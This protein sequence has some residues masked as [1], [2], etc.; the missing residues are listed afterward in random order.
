MKDGAS[1]RPLLKNCHVIH[2]ACAI[3]LFACTQ[4]SA[5]IMDMDFR[6]LNYADGLPDLGSIQDA[7][8]DPLG[9]V[10]LAYDRGLFRYDGHEVQRLAH[11]PTDSTS[12]AEEFVRALYVAADGRVWVGTANRG[13]SIFDPVTSRFSHIRSEDE[14]GPIPA[15]SIWSFYEDDFEMI[16]MAANPGLIRHDVENGTFEHFIFEPEGYSD[17]E[18]DFLNDGRKIL[19]DPRDPDRLLFATRGGLLAFDKQQ[20]SF[21]HHRM[22]YVGPHQLDYLINDF[23][24]TDSSSL[25]MGTWSGH[26][27]LYD[28]QSDTWRQFVDTHDQSGQGIILT[29]MRR[30]KHSLWVVGT[31]GFGYFNMEGGTYTY[32][33]HDPD[34]PESIG[35]LVVP[36]GMLFTRDSTLMVVGRRGVSISNPYPGYDPAQEQFRPY[37]DVIRVNGRVIQGDTSDAFRQQLNLEEDE[38]TLQFKVTWPVYQDPR[39]V[40]Y[41][42][43][44][45]GWETEWNVV[46]HGRIIQYTNLK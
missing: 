9:R 28:T 11:I 17:M 40:L 41:R 3:L 13:I 19:Q 24:F 42:Y 29:I 37:L 34:D 30:S 46:E 25:W 22:P 5:Q 33:R 1:G 14:G 4:T 8:Q 26:L 16:W 21:T 23:L 45:Q 12:V 7:V 44:L 43:R 18:M 36:G 20:R 32:F 38:N 27:L 39:N 15:G 6:H 35:D 2:F 10:W 31:P